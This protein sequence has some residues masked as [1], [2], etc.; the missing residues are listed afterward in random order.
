MRPA[1]EELQSAIVQSLRTVAELGGIFDGA[2]AR[3]SFPYVVIDCGSERDWSFRDLQGRE[4][5]VEITTWDDVPA[6]LARLE[7]AIWNQFAEIGAL[8]TWILSGVT[9]TSR[10]TSRSPAGPWSSVLTARVR[11]L[12]LGQEAQP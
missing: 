4:F 11:L 1:K 7:A 2:P 3:A 8:Q 5:A 12:Q 9:Q 10:R 6:R